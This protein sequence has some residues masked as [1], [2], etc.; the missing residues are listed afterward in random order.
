MEE[1][2]RIIGASALLR[3][4]VELDEAAFLAEE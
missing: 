1:D 2:A 4:A 3:S